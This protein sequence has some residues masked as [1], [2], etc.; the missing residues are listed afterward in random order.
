MCALIKHT[1]TQT[2]LCLHKVAISKYIK[3]RTKGLA[4]APCPSH[5]KDSAKVLQKFHTTK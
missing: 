2:L 4:F 5:L 3:E 1:P